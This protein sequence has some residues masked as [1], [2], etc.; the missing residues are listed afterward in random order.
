MSTQ[1]LNDN[2]LNNLLSNYVDNI[3]DSFDVDT[4]VMYAK[5]MLRNEFRKSNGKVDEDLLINE[6]FETFYGDEESVSDFLSENGVN[7]SQIQ[8]IMNNS[9]MQ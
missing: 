9:L 3:V 2:Q 1:I 7:D 8:R 4:L 6:V 5:D